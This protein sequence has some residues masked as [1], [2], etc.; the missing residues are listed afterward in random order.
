MEEY[1]CW[2]WWHMPVIPVFNDRG[3]GT[4]LSQLGLGSHKPV[5]NS[6]RVNGVIEAQKNLT[7]PSLTGARFFA[8]V[9]HAIASLH[10]P[11]LHQCALDIWQQNFGVQS[12]PRLQ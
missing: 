8:Q 12:S 11:G 3:R 7:T 6:G 9:F 10:H 5:S 2:V 4:V 1:L